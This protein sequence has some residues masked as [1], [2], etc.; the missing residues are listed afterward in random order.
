VYAK[1]RLVSFSPTPPVFAF[2]TVKGAFGIG[3]CY[4]KVGL[5]VVLCFDVVFATSAFANNSEN[6]R[7][8]ADLLQGHW[9][10]ERR[11]GEGIDALSRRP[12][13]L[14]LGVVFVERSQDGGLAHFAGCCSE[15]INTKMTRSIVRQMANAKTQRQMERVTLS[16]EVMGSPEAS[17]C[18]TFLRSQHSLKRRVV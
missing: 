1:R 2:F 15:G 13:R 9:A 8:H 12:K 5:E 18:I 14:V 16:W 17:M 11:R 10:F 4:F 6:G 7:V 3:V